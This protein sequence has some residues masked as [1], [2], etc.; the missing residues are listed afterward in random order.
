MVVLGLLTSQVD[1]GVPGCWF[2]HTTGLAQAGLG[3][4]RRREDEQRAG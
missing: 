1:C 4:C 2:S 3:R